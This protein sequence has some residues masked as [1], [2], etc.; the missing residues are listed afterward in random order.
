MS[1]VTLSLQQGSGHP[2]EGSATSQSEARSFY[3]RAERSLEQSRKLILVWASELEHID[4]VRE[5]KRD[6]FFKLKVCK[7]LIIPVTTMF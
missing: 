1:H 6:V 3:G 4:K 7:R 5:C 2:E